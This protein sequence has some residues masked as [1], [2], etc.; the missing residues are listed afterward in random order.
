MKFPLFSTI[1]GANFLNS[2][3]SP[4]S[5]NPNNYKNAPTDP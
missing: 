3:Q 2:I 5:Y 4:D 1:L